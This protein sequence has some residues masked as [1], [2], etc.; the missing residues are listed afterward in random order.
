MIHVK[1][2]G[3]TSV[4]DARACV[5]AGVSSIGLNFV[6]SSPRVVDVATARA[7]A[8]SV[9]VLVVGVVADLSVE[10]MLSLRKEA[11]LGCLQLHGDEPP[12]ALE[13]LLPHAY[14]AIRVGDEADVARADLYPGEHVLCDAK[15]EGVLGGTGK[16]VD[17]ALVASLARRRKLTLAGGLT[18]G[19]VESAARAVRPF[20]VD[21]ASGVERAGD[22]RRKDHEAIRAFVEAVRRA[23]FERRST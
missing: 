3:I 10:E 18:P 22:P 19:N 14:K 12:A 17:P 23:G 8:A 11:N 7:I 2:C 13:P 9:D 4:E 20:A 21:V 5:A 6:P 15:V 1:V 16:R